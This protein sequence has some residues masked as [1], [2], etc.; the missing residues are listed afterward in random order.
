MAAGGYGLASALG[1]TTLGRV[2][3]RFGRKPSIVVGLILF[4]A[5]F[6]GLIFTNSL[7]LVLFSFAVGGLGEGLMSPALGA[8]FLDISE[9]RH[10]A[11]VMGIKS[12]AGSLGGVVGPLL[13]AVAAASVAP[14]GAFA[15]SVAIVLFG[16]LLVLVVLREPRQLAKKT[17][18]TSEISQQR[19]IAARGSLREIV[20]L[21][22]HRRDS[23]RA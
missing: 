19:A 5:Q 3:D 13:A 17:D 20:A 7:G 9:E 15:A 1:Q 6:A 14:Q 18:L 23:G 4:S 2:G 10:R 12:S 16:V 21:A 22:I 8:F 11:R